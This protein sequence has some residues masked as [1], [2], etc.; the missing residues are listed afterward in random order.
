MCACE[1]TSIRQ[2]DKHFVLVRQIFT[3]LL[4][5]HLA[6]PDASST[7]MSL[8]MEEAHRKK[9]MAT[10]LCDQL[11]QHCS[12][13][14]QS[15]QWPS[16]DCC[17][18]LLLCHICHHKCNGESTGY[19]YCTNIAF[20]TTLPAFSPENGPVKSCDE[21]SNVHLVFFFGDESKVE[22]PF[23]RVIESL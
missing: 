18:Q 20:Q 2:A 1:H 12:A 19:Q 15:G 6:A 22:F 23:V 9:R 11:I 21:F 16:L 4:L 3:P 17:C 7:E 14:D 8:L 13:S 5:V 10:L